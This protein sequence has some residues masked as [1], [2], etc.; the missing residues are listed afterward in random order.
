MRDLAAKRSK[1]RVLEACIDFAS[2]LNYHVFSPL[3]GKT[4]PESCHHDPQ[5]HRDHE[6]MLP[7]FGA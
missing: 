7:G 2:A 5:R 1:Y 6:A 3:L 4:D